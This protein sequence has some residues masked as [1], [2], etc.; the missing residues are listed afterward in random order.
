M[1]YLQL[2]NAVLKRLREDS[3][4]GVA[5]TSYSSMISEFVNDAKGLVEDAWQWS[6]QRTRYTVTTVDGTAEYSL[7]GSSNR[8]IIESVWDESHGIWLQERNTRFITEMSYLSG[9]QKGASNYWAASGVDGNGDTQITLHLIP[10][11]AYTI[12][13]DGFQRQSDLSDAN[14]VLVVP[15]QPVLL[16]AYE[17]AIR[18]RGE[19]GGQT[20]GEAFQFAQQSLS[21][22]IARDNSLAHYQLDWTVE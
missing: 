7:T 18:E 10:D 11:D 12:Y 6:A 17:L 3:V 19:V 8:C 13:V 4:T 1:T 22:A 21:D 15:E 16:L 14:D 20:V 9:D 2:I 5:D